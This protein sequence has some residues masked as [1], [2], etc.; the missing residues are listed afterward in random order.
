ML[1]QFEIAL[2]GFLHTEA[3]PKL[4]ELK[5]NKGIRIKI[6]YSKKISKSILKHVTENK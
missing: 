4:G 3:H 6:V 2:H 1:V 5:F